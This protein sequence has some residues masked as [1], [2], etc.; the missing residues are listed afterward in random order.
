M[1]RP[2]TKFIESFDTVRHAPG[3]PDR[4]MKKTHAEIEL[5]VSLLFAEPMVVPEAVSFDSLGFL[6]IAYDVLTAR[7]KVIKRARGSPAHKP[8]LL[9]LRQGRK[10]TY[11]NYLGMISSHLA[12]PMFILSSNPTLDKQKRERQKLAKN[13]KR[14]PARAARRE[15][16][17][18]LGRDVVAKI[19]FLNGYFSERG[20]VRK[21]IENAGLLEAYIDQLI[22]NNTN[23]RS[24]DLRRALEALRRR[25][26]LSNRSEVRRI[27]RDVIDQKSLEGAVEYIDSCYN[28][29]VAESVKATT[30]LYSTGGDVKNDLVLEAENS[31]NRFPVSPR[32]NSLSLLMPLDKRVIKPLISWE[33]VWEKTLTD[34]E[35][36]ESVKKLRQAKLPPQSVRRV[37]DSF[38]FQK[39]LYEEALRSHVALL[40][41]KL[42][43]EQE[44]GWKEE[45]TDRLMPAVSSAMLA[46]F[47]DSL[48]GKVGATALGF[49]AGQRKRILK[50]VVKGSIRR[51]Y[52]RYVEY[53]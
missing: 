47:I 36:V 6:D 48:A 12:D 19:D 37:K 33:D 45:I 29:V 25:V 51:L 27:G 31:V 9:A 40:A 23:K 52:G 49:L 16:E 1:T 13:I 20:V 34:D 30:A 2:T 42:T 22:M 26:N 11:N 53:G 3:A 44:I 14:L 41:K 7:Q 32:A 10:A 28:R 18:V 21:A 4:D 39:E 38:P 8:F 5:M 24:L 15:A 46:Y 35:W 50:D 17:E 43:S